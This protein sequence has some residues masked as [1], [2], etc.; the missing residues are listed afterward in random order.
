MK[1][2]ILELDKKQTP[3]DKLYNTISLICGIV[4]LVF[5]AVSLIIQFI[6]RDVA[7]AIW[8]YGFYVAFICV[9]VGMACATC[10]LIR[11]YYIISIA[12]FAMSA[13]GFAAL[14]T[15][16]IVQAVLYKQIFLIPFY[17]L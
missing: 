15:T 16:V 1:K 11:N 12:S 3:S 13:F 4:G 9:I 17:F 2:D 5:L 8:Q 7:L 10:E 14:I 6:S